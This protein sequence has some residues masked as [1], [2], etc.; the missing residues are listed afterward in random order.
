MCGVFRGQDQTV[1]APTCYLS[2]NYFSSQLPTQPSWVYLLMGFVCGIRESFC[3]VMF[4]W[5]MTS[6]NGR[7]REGARS[8]TVCDYDTVEASSSL[9]S[10]IIY[11]SAAD[12]CF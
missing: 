11:L 5:G 3:K 4:S 7:G 8:F 2:G 6:S 1:V 12:Y 10:D 9:C